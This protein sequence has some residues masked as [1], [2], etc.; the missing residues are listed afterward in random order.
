[1]LI[2]GLPGSGKTTLAKK[3]EAE[4]NAIRFSPDEWIEPLLADPADI[5]ERDRLRDPV[6]NLQWDL[7][8]QYLCKGLTV[9]LENGFW[10]E[11]ERSLYAMAAIE[12][13][14]KVELH[15]LQVST[16][17]LW[18]RVQSRNAMLKSETFVMSR[19]D[20]EVGWRFFQPP[21]QPELEFYD[22]WSV[23]TAGQPLDPRQRVIDIVETFSEA[24]AIPV[25]G[26]HLSLEV[27]GKRFGWFMEN[28]HGNGRIEINC[29]GFPGSGEALVRANEAV[30]FIPKMARNRGWGVGIWLDVPG[31]EWDEVSE[32][33]HDAYL[34][35]SAKA[36]RPRPAQP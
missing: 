12:L 27:R 25:A 9:I 15:F 8:E 33:L 11:E 24:A 1:M 6:E 36:K 13:G 4:R 30:Y 29:K 32:V 7:A 5:V 28:H 20:V 2:C 10:A 16:D 26:L 22:D 3:M 18:R 34:I 19:E 35:T 31:L 23:T 21:T 14:A 17:E